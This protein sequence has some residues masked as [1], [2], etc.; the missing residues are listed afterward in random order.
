MAGWLLRRQMQDQDTPARIA[1]RLRYSAARAQVQREREG[2][3]P[4]ITVENA[5]EVIAW[6]ERRL[7][8]L[9]E[10]GN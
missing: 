1:E 3:Y 2:V 4:T 6:Q 7:R 8:E 5:N 10:G 9:T